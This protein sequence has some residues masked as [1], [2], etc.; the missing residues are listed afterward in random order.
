MRPPSFI[1]IVKIIIFI[2][3]SALLYS[4]SGPTII[5]KSYK[6]QIQTPAKKVPSSAKIPGTQ[7]P[8]KIKGKTYFP[9]PSS[10]GYAQKGIASWYGHPFHGR[11]TSNGE[12]YNMHKMTAAHKTLPMNT[13]LLVK[14]LENGKE[15]VVR[16]NDRGPFIKGRIIDLSLAGAK[17]IGLKTRGTA[18]VRLSVLGEAVS[19]QKGNVTK[20]RFL[21]HQDYDA[22]EFY[23]QV[24]SFSIAANAERLARK[25]TNWG[26]EVTIQPFNQAGTRFYRV[27][28][29]AGNSLKNAQREERVF[30]ESGFPDA[31]VVAR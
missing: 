2:S 18:K 14:N 22:G 31:F 15:I 7:R 16:I 4:C 23:I 9:L 12:T 8:Y 30:T 19:Y 26:S 1:L 28:V 11:K 29:R 10:E 20:R 13:N 24:G 17:K 3:Y 6:R 21:P 5:S 27:Q 25:I